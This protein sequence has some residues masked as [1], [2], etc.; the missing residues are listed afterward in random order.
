M[1]NVTERQMLEKMKAA[2][3]ANATDIAI[4]EANTYSREI[5]EETAV[6][7]KAIREKYA[8]IKADKLA[9]LKSVDVGLDY[10]IKMQATAIAEKTVASEEG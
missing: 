1:D 10:L 8:K 7:E 6:A 3:T 4:E 5:A 2:K 9:A